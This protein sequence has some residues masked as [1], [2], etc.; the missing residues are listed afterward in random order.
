MVSLS[1][2]LASEHDTLIRQVKS[3]A[4]VL[5]TPVTAG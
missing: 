3:V 4:H 2:L 5:V 1:A